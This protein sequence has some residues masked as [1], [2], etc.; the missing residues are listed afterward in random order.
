MAVVTPTAKAQFIDAAGVPLAGG[1]LYTYEAG[2]TTPQATYTDSTAATANSNPIILDSRG[3]ANI[4]L[5][6]ADYK[7]KLTDSEGTEIWT[8][9]NIAAPST[10]LSPVFSSNV[11]IS[12]NTSGPALLVTQTGA[13]AAIRVQD[14]ADP[15]SSPFVVDTSGQVGIGTATPA[16][17]IDVAGGAIQ[18]STSGGVARTVMSADSTD[19]IFSVNDDRNF[20]VKTNAATRLTI[21]STAATSTVPVV[22]PSDP[23][24]ALQASTKQYVDTLTGAPA[25]VIMA[26]AG[27]AAPTGFLSCD[28]SAVSR[29]TYATLFAAIG[30]TWGAGNGS[31]TFNVPDLRGMFV[32]GT[33]T[34]ATGSSSGAVG[35]S[36]GAY[37]ADTYLN[38]THTDSGHTHT[39]NIGNSGITWNTTSTGGSS[40]FP[41][42]STTTATGTA[43]IQTS[44]TGGTET[45]PK[46]YGVLYIIKT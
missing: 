33:G 14:S 43:N 36:V 32:R 40:V 38:H 19:S 39:I 17:A 46:N 24:T 9:D 15:D 7:F 22:L 18:I 25:G 27:A 26:F 31:T 13:G 41:G 11:T 10:A 5:S 2:T 29:T 44:T 8:V 42:Y 1:F 12:A 35:P 45:K 28:G 6:S 16:N 37:A 4:W 30:T 23:T 34:N 21:N 20:T 3:E